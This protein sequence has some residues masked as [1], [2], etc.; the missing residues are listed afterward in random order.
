[1]IIN[2]TTP[3]TPAP[4]LVTFLRSDLP[5]LSI[6]P[7]V[8]P[9][10][11][12]ESARP[13]STP[14]S[15]VGDPLTQYL[16]QATRWPRL[17]A[18]EEFR[19]GRIIKAGRDAEGNLTPEAWAARDQLVSAN[20]RL[21][22]HIAKQFNVG[23]D[24]TMDLISPG[25]LGL[26][27]A[28]HKY[29]AA[30][31]YRFSTYAYWGI[32]STIISELNFSQ[33]TVRLPKNVQEQLTKLRQS[34][35][36][37]LQA[38]GREATDTELETDLSWSAE[39]LAEMQCFQQRGCSLDAPLGEDSECTL[40]A[41]LK[42]ED[43]ENPLQAALRADDIELLRQLFTLLTDR[44]GEILRLRNGI[45]GPTETLDA[46]GQRFHVSRERIRQLEECALRKLRLA[47]RS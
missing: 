36:R 30:F 17:E 11:S 5:D 27:Q 4:E 29:D 45:G 23:R 3:A 39:K 9:E 44:E 34:T 13:T 32:R 24:E 35:E 37:L 28:A 21:V 15:E 43:A 25:H 10:D 14:S 38:L 19:L 46:I 6:L 2:P 18:E 7:F 41:T 16:D 20:L 40:G 31:G 1:M 8:R 12:T 33:R 42:D 26:M 47:A 22:Y